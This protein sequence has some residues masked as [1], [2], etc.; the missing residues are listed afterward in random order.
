MLNN[1][2][3]SLLGA[4][5]R[6]LLAS[7]RSC[8]IR[9]SPFPFLYGSMPVGAVTAEAFGAM[10]EM[11]PLGKGGTAAGL[12]NPEEYR[13]ISRIGEIAD[14]RQKAFWEDALPE[15]YCSQLAN[16]LTQKFISFI[17]S[18]RRSDILG[19]ARSLL[20]TEM[21]SRFSAISPMQKG[22][23]I[24][25]S[26]E[27]EWMLTCDHPGYAL[28]AHTDH[29]RKMITFLLY[30]SKNEKGSIAPGTS[31]FSPFSN[32]TRSWDSV[33][34]GQSKFAEVFRANHVEGHFLA[35]VKSDI[36]WHGVVPS[37]ETDSPRMTINLTVKRPDFLGG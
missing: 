19:Y 10:R 13:Y 23:L 16:T 37:V 32:R 28:E 7:V 34:V 25:R 11:F 30:L 36:S 15:V 33:R 35:F 29:P 18:Y 5:Q 20:G 9:P 31:I 27:Y 1:D 2:M 3:G 4:F 22:A 21:T 8:S 24:S 12:V 26:A 17:P 6:N 14:A